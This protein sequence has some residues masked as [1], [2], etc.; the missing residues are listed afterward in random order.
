MIRAC[1]VIDL[2]IEILRGSTNVKD[3]K[4][5]L[6]AGITDGIKF[7][8]AQSKKDAAQLRFT[9]RQA[10]AILE[11]RL[12]KLIG[13]EIE[14]LLK[15]H[16]KTLANIAEYEE[17]L[18]NRG[19]MAKVII[20]ELEGYKKEYQTPRKTVIDNLEEVVLEEKK[21]EE[22]DVV[23]LM[24]RFGYA[25]TVD[26]A[27]YERNKDAADAENRYVLTCKNT[28]KI[29]IFTNKGQMHLLKV[30]DLP[31]GKF[32]DK[33]TPID[34]LSNYN[35][36]EENFVY[37]TNL[38]SIS[39]SKLVFGTK[40]S[41]LKMVDG[42]EFDVAKRTTAATKLNEN[43]EVLF[44]QRIEGDETIVMQSEKDF[45]LRIE[46]AAIPEKKKGA[47]GVRGM[48]LGAGDTLCGIY[49]LGNGENVNVEV[50]GK[51]YA[52]NRL[53]IGNRDTKGTKR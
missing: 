43:D 53:H 45:F 19:A 35:S 37:I 6:T 47:V 2:I 22:M 21:I 44:V 13:L 16:E 24:D 23:F 42:A 33:G 46:V 50:K 27:T 15:D 11:M 32:R 18:S 51:E 9:E 12:Y 34:N 10:D 28:D 26:V 25:K 38:G 29:C 30:L 48:K 52:L 41:M 5:C 20:R 17:I 31:F 7:K 1:D 3:A 39:T 8:S 14:A 49:L 36:S 4:A 40:A